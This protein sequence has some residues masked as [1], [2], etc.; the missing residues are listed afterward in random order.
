M[1][2]VLSRLVISLCS[3]LIV[4]GTLI[5]IGFNKP[6]NP[7]KFAVHFN[8]CYE[9]TRKDLPYLYCYDSEYLSDKLFECPQRDYISTNDKSEEAFY[10][11]YE[12]FK[13]QPYYC[14]TFESEHPHLYD[15]PRLIGSPDYNWFGDVWIYNIYTKEVDYWQ[16]YLTARQNFANAVEL[17]GFK[18]TGYFDN[19]RY[20]CT[21][22]N[23]SGQWWENFLPF[24]GMCL[25]AVYDACYNTFIFTISLLNSIGT[26]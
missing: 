12:H 23:D 24:A 18:E 13:N 21:Q 17:G 8:E 6:F 25:M 4:I 19:T 22:L 14:F 16:Q 11:W 1:K 5:S 15:L 20:L 26:Y 9:N 10:R 2:N 7:L 3:F